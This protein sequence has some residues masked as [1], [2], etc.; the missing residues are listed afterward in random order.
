M[1]Q[2]TN[3][4]SSSFF[5]RLSLAVVLTAILSLAANYQCHANYLNNA[6][7]AVQ[8][9]DDSGGWIFDDSTYTN[10]PKTGKRVDQ[11]KKEKTA[12]RDPNAFFDSPLLGGFFNNDFFGG[13][14]DNY[15]PLLYLSTISELYG[16]YFYGNDSDKYYPYDGDPNEEEN[17]DQ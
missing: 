4:N 12:Y 13:F 11:Y 7:A 16:N 15:N 1:K 14:Y 2:Q 10:D 6:N 9:D 3:I 17:Q 8:D 5:I